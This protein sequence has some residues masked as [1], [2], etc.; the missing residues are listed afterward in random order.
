VV[1]AINQYATGN[2]VFQQSVHTVREA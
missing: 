1:F 2:N